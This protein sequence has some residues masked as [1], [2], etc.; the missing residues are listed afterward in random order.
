MSLLLKRGWW[1]LLVL[2]VGL[3]FWRLRFD[4]DVLN[5]LPDGLPVVQGLKLYQKHFTSMRELVITVRAPSADEAESAARQIAESLRQETN[6][7]AEV[8][9]QPPWIEH[10]EQMGELIAYLWLN[11]PPEAFAQLAKRLAPEA[12]PSLLRETREQLA[13]S[14]SP[15]ELGR[16][17]YDPFGLTRLPETGLGDGAMFSA[18]EAGFA[19][20]DGAFR[21]VFVEARGTLEGYRKCAAWFADIQAAVGRCQSSPSWPGGATVRY[22][23]APPFT[24]EIA[25]GMERDMQGS[26]LATLALIV[27]LFWWAHR[28]WRPLVLLLLMLACVVAGALAAGGLLFS[29]LNAVSLGFAAILMG[30][31]VDYGL[32]IYHE[33]LAAPRLSARALQRL[34]APSVIWSAVTTATAFGLLNFAGLPGLSQLG[35]LVGIGILLAA[36]LMLCAF[37]PL[38]LRWG[39]PPSLAPSPPAGTPSHAP[40]IPQTL[41]TI[42]PLPFGRGEGRGGGSVLSS[43][44]DAGNG[45]GD[46][47]ER[48]GT[49][50][51]PD[52]NRGQRLPRAGNPLAG[53][54]ARGALV[55]P[56]GA[57]AQRRP[58]GVGRTA[59]RAEPPG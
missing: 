39:K 31:T 24:T 50:P 34:I 47:P 59:N 21:A 44:A 53:L 2:A 36:A 38:V 11:Q 8:V 7:V 20:A 5:L 26:V 19:S 37:L 27:L 40:P 42:P 43:G 4:V 35:S 33:W 45:R 10:P 55:E 30:L 25:T 3:G 54:A 23:G 9:W 48:R 51:L 29:R 41:P 58:G 14:L 1:A 17:S 32:V 13:T 57:Q 28:S 56:V 15:M 46:F 6:L 18:S 22:T 16:L 12:L 49:A 52:P